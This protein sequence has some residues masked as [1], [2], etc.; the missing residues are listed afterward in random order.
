MH[1]DDLLAES[2]E[3]RMRASHR[4]QSALLA[5]KRADSTKSTR[6]ADAQDRLARAKANM[7]LLT[8][9]ELVG[10]DAYRLLNSKAKPTA[11]A[12]LRGR[13]AHWTEDAMT[14]LAEKAT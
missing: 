9:E 5:K 2:R 14:G 12:A 3:A 1:A 7:L 10:F 4:L 6:L 11:P 8:P 13:S